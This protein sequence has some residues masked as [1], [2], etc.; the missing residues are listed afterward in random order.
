MSGRYTLKGERTHS[1]KEKENWKTAAAS[2]SDSVGYEKPPPWRSTRVAKRGRGEAKVD[3]DDTTDDDDKAAGNLD[4][5][6]P[7]VVCS[8]CR[9][10]AD[11][12]NL[13]V[14]KKQWFWAEGAAFED[15]GVRCNCHGYK[16]C[17]I[18]CLN[19]HIDPD[20][21]PSDDPRGRGHSEI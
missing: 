18:A 16:F 14:T 10:V 13:K 6:I 21:P 12:E 11:F 5:E 3:N 17:N 15:V 19:R 4:K 9:R 8:Q 2:G 20:Y 7:L 1:A